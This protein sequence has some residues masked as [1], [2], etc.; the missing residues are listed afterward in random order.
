MNWKLLLIASTLVVGLTAR[1]TED[2]IIDAT[3]IKLAT[4]AATALPQKATET[5]AT[6]K[7]EAPEILTTEAPS[8]VRYL[9]ASLPTKPTNKYNNNYAN[10]IT[11]HTLN[12]IR[13]LTDASGSI[14]NN[15]NSNLLVSMHGIVVTNALPKTTVEPTTSHSSSRPLVLFDGDVNPTITT[16][17]A[18]F[19]YGTT[20]A[21]YHV[22]P[23]KILTTRKKK[24][25]IHKIISKWSDNPHEVFNLHGGQSILAAQTTKVTEIN[26]LKDHLVQNA[27]NPVV[28]TGSAPPFLGQQ[29]L[30]HQSITNR[31][32]SS[33]VSNTVHVFKKKAVK[34]KCRN[35]KV[36]LGNKIVNSNKI[37]SKE[38]C[39][40]VNLEIDNKIHNVN[41][42]STSDKIPNN[43][44]F[45]DASD[46]ESE[47][48]SDYDSEY[49]SESDEGTKKQEIVETATPQFINSITQ[50]TKPTQGLK[51]GNKVK[52]ISKHRKKKPASGAQTGEDNGGGDM[53]SMV[54]TVMTMMAIFNPL[55]LGVWGVIFSPVAAVTFGGM[56]FAMYHFMNSPAMKGWSSQPVWVKPQEIIIKNRIKHTPIPVKV[57]HLHKNIVHTLPAKKIIAPIEFHGR[58]VSFS[59]PREYGPPVEDSYG[60]PVEDSYGPPS[61]TKPPKS[62]GEPPSIIDDYHPSA[63]SGGPYKRKS[64]Y[65]SKRPVVIPTK[66]S[67]RFKLL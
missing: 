54:M 64:H 41:S 26:Q 31:P 62:Y 18:F 55:N 30:H 65:R 11:K 42:H 38:S 25:V 56:F 16:R 45:E 66:N 59:P 44:K 35:I 22:E 46:S 10:L 4:E 40:D 24:P 13:N 7:A 20:W 43:D 32:T 14:N 29:I 47:S 17:R 8:T 15:N 2:S 51:A 9:V 21:N 27:F 1:P 12:R 53:G 58:P 5:D 37:S 60:P 67:Y 28:T 49:D 36:K 61:L 48:D 39:G 63:P 3:T 19:P 33:S 23:P 52:G 50:I 34:D 57:V 6:K